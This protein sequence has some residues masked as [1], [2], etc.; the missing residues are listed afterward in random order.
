MNRYTFLVEDEEGI[1]GDIR[2][3]AGNRKEA[4]D[5]VRNWLTN[6]EMWPNGSLDTPFTLTL[7]NEELA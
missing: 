7:T 2:Q 6:N 4:E 1:W 5:R 3:R